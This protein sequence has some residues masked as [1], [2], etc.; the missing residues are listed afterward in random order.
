MIV[1]GCA[2]G[3]PDMHVRSFIRVQ[4]EIQI[5][6]IELVL[7]AGLPIIQFIG[8]P[9]QALKESALRI[10]SAIRAQGFDFPAHQQVLVHLKPTHLRKSSRGLDLAVAAALLWETDQLPRPEGRPLLYGELTL[11]GEVERPSDLGECHLEDVVWTG[12]GA[13]LAG[14]ALEVRSLNGL[15]HPVWKEPTNQADALMRPSPRVQSFDLDSAEIGTLLAAG[16]HSALICGP[17]GGGKTTLVEAVGCWI[18]EPNENALADLRRRDPALTWRPILRPHHTSS[19]LAMVGGGAQLWAGEIAKASHGVLIL[20]ELLEFHP[21]VQD[22]LREPMDSGSIS[23]AR[24]GSAK[25]FEA[26]TLV[27]ATTNLCRCGKFLP[28]SQD[29]SRCRCKTFD[30]RR[31]LARLTGPFADRFAVLHFAK[32]PEREDQFLSVE[33]IQERVAQAVEF[34]KSDRGQLEP[35]GWAEPEIIARTLTSFQRQNI[36]EDLP[37]SSRR[38]QSAVLR[39][40]RTLADI[41]TTRKISD[42]HLAKAVKICVRNHHL[43][44]TSDD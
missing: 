18:E 12:S 13:P 28:G 15:R 22:A 9:D 31:N 40:A 26:R 41:E 32:A 6:E 5:V 27:L 33:T 23:I 42:R 37:M 25:T 10:R 2:G 43:L 39:V 44:E 20:D 14:A 19:S 21:D 17:Q 7:V 35:N 36:L 1:Q 8:L 34:R 3:R 24:A 38:R 4:S 11:K 29:K 16:E 30:R